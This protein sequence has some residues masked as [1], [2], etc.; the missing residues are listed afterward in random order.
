[1]A[2]VSAETER[3]LATVVALVRRQG[4]SRDEVLLVV[5]TAL[6]RAETAGLPSIRERMQAHQSE[7]A[8]SRR[9]SSTPDDQTND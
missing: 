5:D 1:M 7:L 9:A 2:V 4:M 3:H 8:E 6:A